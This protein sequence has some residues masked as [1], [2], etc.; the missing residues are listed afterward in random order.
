LKSN[1][2]TTVS[3]SATFTVATSYTI[4]TQLVDGA[5]NWNVA[6]LSS[7]PSPFTV[8]AGELANV[9]GLA[10]K[11]LQIGVQRAPSATE[12]AILFKV[13]RQGQSTPNIYRM[14]LKFAS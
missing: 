1:A 12:G 10:R 14:A 9:E 8:T 4:T 6:L 13:L 2:D 7:T 11:T 3:L 5:T